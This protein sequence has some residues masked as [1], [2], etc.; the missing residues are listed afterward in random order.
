MQRVLGISLEPCAL[1]SRVVH[2]GAKS[3]CCMLLRSISVDPHAPPAFDKR[4]LQIRGLDTQVYMPGRSHQHPPRTSENPEPTAC[5]SLRVESARGGFHQEHTC[6]RLRP[7]F[8]NLGSSYSFFC[9]SDN[10]YQNL[11]RCFILSASSLFAGGLPQHPLAF[12][13]LTDPI[14]LH[15]TETA[16]R[17]HLLLLHSP[18]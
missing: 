2:W 15:L 3:C 10:Y 7:C 13:C 17:F 16:A 1:A 6:S 18:Q 11:V 12:E 4:Q 9:E 8:V 14:N 5:I